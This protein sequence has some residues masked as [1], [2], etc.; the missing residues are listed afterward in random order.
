MYESFLSKLLP[1][2]YPDPTYNKF[3]EAFNKRGNEW[4]HYG[5]RNRYR[6]KREDNPDG[7]VV[8]RHY[9]W[10]GTLPAGGICLDKPATP[11]SR[12]QVAINQK[13]DAEK[14]AEEQQKHQARLHEAKALIKSFKPLKSG[15]SQF[16]ED[17]RI[18]AICGLDLADPVLHDGTGNA[19]I[20]YRNNLGEL[21]TF[22]IL[23][24]SRYKPKDKP[25]THGLHVKNNYHVICARGKYLKDCAVIAI[26][27]SYSNGA[28]L[29]LS[30]YRGYKQAG[31]LAVIV[32]GNSG[33]LKPVFNSL[34][35]KLGKFVCILIADNDLAR[36]E[37][38][39]GVEKCVEI[40]KENPDM[41]IT[42]FTPVD[43]GKKKQ[44]E[45][46]DLSDMFVLY[47][48]AVTRQT[49]IN[50]LTDDA[51]S[52]AI[53]TN[54]LETISYISQCRLKGYYVP[55]MP[56]LAIPEQVPEQ[57]TDFNLEEF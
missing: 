11:L 22:Q 6:L 40:K 8:M 48:E 53:L 43:F 20:I 51:L 24:E 39:I 33:N 13:A 31:G 36:V 54:N 35:Q 26:T 29:Y 21:C 49:I 46:F 45:N 15:D 5:Q 50:G 3:M 55:V 37:G 42:V 44:G 30:M 41:N 18:T 7:S 1:R 57:L 25:F 34:K 32:A 47:G 2:G 14:K 56:T 17:K 23:K 16:M 28:S 38:N 19:V 52:Q 10:G 4:I 9:D 12:E 27:E